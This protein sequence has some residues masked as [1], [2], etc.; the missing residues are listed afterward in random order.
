MHYGVFKSHIIIHTGRNDLNAENVIRLSQINML[1]CGVD[2]HLEIVCLY[3]Y[4]YMYIFFLYKFHLN[5]LIYSN[6]K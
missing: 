1:K 2:T 6:R 4:I 3:I 5:R